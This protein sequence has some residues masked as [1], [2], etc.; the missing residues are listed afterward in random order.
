MRAARMLPGHEKPNRNASTLVI[1]VT[2]RYL[3]CVFERYG[4]RVI[5]PEIK[6]PFCLLFLFMALG[7]GAYIPAPAQ[8]AALPNRERRPLALCD[9]S[10]QFN[11]QDPPIAW[12]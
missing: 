11:R 9:A 3:P 6:L 10:V 7:T 8:K 5:E 4:A 1:G 2:P 12:S